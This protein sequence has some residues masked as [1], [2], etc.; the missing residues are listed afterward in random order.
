MTS[1]A[2]TAEQEQLRQSVREFLADKS[3][4][5]EVRR[6]METADGYDPAVWAQ[7]AGQLGLVGLAIPEEYGGSGFSYAELV[8]VLEEM[9]RTLLCAPYFA[10][11]A[12]AANAIL[13]A[14]DEAARRELLPGIA[15]GTVVATVALT[16][17]SGRWDAD[18]IQLAARP[19]SDGSYALTGHKAFVIDGQLAGLIVVAARTTEGIALLTVAG[20]AAGLTRTTQ[21]TMDMTRKQARLEFDGTPARLL[22]QGDAA[23]AALA[24]TLDRAAVALAAEQVGGARQCLDM[25]VAY[26]K[27]R[28][29]F[30]RPIG[31]F[32]AIKHKCAEMLV[33]VES[34]RSAAAYAGWVAAYRPAE[35]PAAASLAKAFCSDTYFRTAGQTIQIH[36]GIG[37][38][39]EHD[40][41]LH[42]KRA[43]SAGLL[44]GDPVYHRE[45]L[46]QRIGL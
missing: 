17:D 33:A 39:W 20:D 2:A 11:V 35:L 40:A 41:H 8:V 45:L 22:C 14:G 1:F 46:A 27:T 32:Q 26:A 5:P 31:S 4:M 3:P 34:A 25:S 10:S 19:A 42:F 30:G 24:V 21:P 12:L 6:L 28:L 16:E 15:D 38:T 44:L 7:L 18:G 9:G 36:G 29:Q 37:F 23:A 13:A 43:K